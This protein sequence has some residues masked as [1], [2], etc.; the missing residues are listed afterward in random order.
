MPE[1]AQTSKG[2]WPL[3]F[4]SI[5]NR[6][7]SYVIEQSFLVLV[8][9][10]LTY[11]FGMKPVILGVFLAYKLNFLAAV[12]L[13]FATSTGWINIA[14]LFIVS[15]LYYTFE[16]GSRVRIGTNIFG[17]QIVAKYELP[18]IQLFALSSL[19]NLVKSFFLANPGNAL[20]I[21]VFRQRMQTLVDHC[22]D[23]VVATEKD[24]LKQS[25]CEFP[26]I[27]MAWRY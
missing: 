13:I 12:N 18:P 26:F 17:F 4:A 27:R 22:F 14:S 16:S 24:E 8:S 3:K 20:F 7:V 11:S 6:Y 23:I 25:F 1:K 5:P 9:A 2:S 10:L 21:I 19:R 15:F